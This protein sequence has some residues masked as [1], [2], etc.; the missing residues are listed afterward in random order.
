ML[1]SEFMSRVKRAAGMLYTIGPVLVIAVGLA[2]LGTLPELHLGCGR[3]GFGWL[4]AIPRRLSPYV[5]ALKVV[6]SPSLATGVPEWM[7]FICEWNS[8]YAHLPWVLG[9]NCTL[10]AGPIPLSHRW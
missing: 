3:L 10:F 2:A 9:T 4:E 1:T 7:P 6:C 8:M 5:G